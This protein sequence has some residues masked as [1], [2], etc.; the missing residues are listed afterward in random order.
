MH[1]GLC[2]TH[3]CIMHALIE[4]RNRLV[5]LGAR[6]WFAAVVQP[7]LDHVDYVIVNFG[8]HYHDM[9]VYRHDMTELA[10]HL[11]RWVAH[12]GHASF[13]E[14]SAQHFMGAAGTGDYDARDAF[15]CV[16]VWGCGVAWVQRSPRRTENVRNVG[17]TPESLQR[18]VLGLR[19]GRR[20]KSRAADAH[21]SG[22][23]TSASI[24]MTKTP[25]SGTYWQDTQGPWCLRLF[26]PR[27][28]C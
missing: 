16:G 13:R 8:L 20:T 25:S 2:S 4:P 19:A 23:K 21:R 5:K 28:V 6:R 17:R 12:G 14:T 22:P 11:T 18:G 1:Q 3:R 27:G 9:G 7:V 10:R 24:R 15:R 26:L